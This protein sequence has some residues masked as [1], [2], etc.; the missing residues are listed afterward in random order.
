MNS[1]NVL[2]PLELLTKVTDLLCY[3]DTSSYDCAIQSDYDDVMGA[4]Q[5]KLEAVQL[6][7]LYTKMVTAKDGDKRFDSRL[8]Y[9]K[10]RHE[11]RG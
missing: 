11:H 10:L 2:I 5:K 3:W 6:H 8:E 7:R 4:I 1:K 9:L